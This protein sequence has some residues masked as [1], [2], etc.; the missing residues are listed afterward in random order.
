MLSN[1]PTRGIMDDSSVDGISNVVPLDALTGPGIQNNMTF[2][3]QVLLPQAPAGPA[4]V[5]NV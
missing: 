4:L 5:S 3:P 2:L 1:N